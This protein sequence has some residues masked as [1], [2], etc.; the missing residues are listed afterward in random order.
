MG[1]KVSA[2]GKIILSGE[3]SVVYG[4][5]AIAAAVNWRLVRLPDGKVES[6][7]PIGAGLGSS[8]AYAVSVS[9]AKI[10]KLDL[11]RINRLAY[12]IEKKNHGSPSGVD[13]TT[14]TYGG[15]L[16]YRKEAENFK[17]FKQIEAKRKLPKLF[18]LNTGRPT[19]S[20]KDMVEY[21]A[22]LRKKRGLYV[23]KIFRKIEKVTRS[24]LNYLSKESNGNFGHLIR[25]NERL[26]ESLG[27]VS[28][29]T[30]AIIERIEKMGGYAKITGA[31]GREKGS[32]MV[33]VYH[34]DVEK[35]GLF[36][37]ENNLNMMP[38]KLGGEGV[39]IER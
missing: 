34:K 29:S 6:K 18:L 7:I 23:E 1:I 38:V 4:Y 25:D 17:T 27:V 37:K 28:E 32:G 24:F 26:L 16:W 13:N 19:E 21:V 36:A 3:H 15:F 22:G 8:A 9:A 20:T 11:E 33:L 5:P 39:R 30:K 35:I 31:G 2:P 12:Q 10:K 14:S